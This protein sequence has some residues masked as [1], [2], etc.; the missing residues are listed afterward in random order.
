MRRGPNLPGM[1]NDGSVHDWAMQFNTL[2]ETELTHRDFAA[3]TQVPVLG[4]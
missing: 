3:M 1:H 4:A 2:T